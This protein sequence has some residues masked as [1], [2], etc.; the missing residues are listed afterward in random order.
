MVLLTSGSS[1]LTVSECQ[2]L[3]ILT[4]IKREVNVNKYEI[5]MSL[6]CRNG[7]PVLFIFI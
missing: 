5:I 7:L 2:L 4:D 1:V 6:V 3:K